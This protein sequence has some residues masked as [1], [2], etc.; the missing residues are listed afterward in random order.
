[1][2]TGQGKAG[3]TPHVEHAWHWQEHGMSRQ[4]ER[5][6]E[7][8]TGPV[9][10]GASHRSDPGCS[11]HPAGSPLPVRR[12]AHANTC[13]K[14][15]LVQASGRMGRRRIRNKMC[16]SAHRVAD[17]LSL[18]GKEWTPTANTVS[19]FYRWSVAL[20]VL[21]KHREKTHGVPYGWSGRGRG[22]N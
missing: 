20:L 3:G 22:G 6:W 11:K 5:R 15:V 17:C 2:G 4:R 13:T 1:M 12:S 21:T 9:S 8:L 18:F 19:R 10:T 7:M 16:A 14:Y